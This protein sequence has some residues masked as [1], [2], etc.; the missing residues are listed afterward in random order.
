MSH[1]DNQRVRLTKRIFRESLIG[2][3]HEKKLHQITVSELCGRAELNR[4]TF[5][6]YYGNVYDVF[7]EIENEMIE[8]SKRCI[9]QIHNTNIQVV[10]QPLYHLLCYIRENADI[11]RMLLDNSVNSEFSVRLIDHTM[12]F[13]RNYSVLLQYDNQAYEEYVFSYLISGSIDIT[14][15]WI[16]TGTRETPEEIAGLIYRLAA[17]ILGLVG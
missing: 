13:L 6:K 4:S 17:K 7:A 10:L 1:T 9:H 14:K 15:N 2:L 12:A 8:Q 16:E 5:Y 3:L 11:Y